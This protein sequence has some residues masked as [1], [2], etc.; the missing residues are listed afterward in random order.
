MNETGSTVF[1]MVET[2]EILENIDEVAA[3]PGV[4]VL[5]VGANDLGIEIGCLGNWDSKIFRDA[6]EKVSLSCRKHRKIMG[7]A[8]LYHRPDIMGWAIES[9]GVRYVLGGLDLG[10]LSA[11]MV[12]NSRTLR[13]LDIKKNGKKP[14]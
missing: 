10:M 9:L 14:H 13:D 4:D 12:V 3:V 8:G 5:L 2:R 1:L 7:L 11:A 6:L